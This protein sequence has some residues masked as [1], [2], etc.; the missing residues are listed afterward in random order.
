VCG[1][2]VVG[3]AEGDGPDAGG[4]TDA[5]LDAAVDV[6]TADADALAP[7]LGT[8]TAEL[9]ASAEDAG[10][11]A[12]PF[13][14]D[15][16]DTGDED[17][18]AAPAG[19]LCPAD[20]DDGDGCTID[21][22]DPESGCVHLP[23]D[24]S[25]GDACTAD[26]CTADDG[27]THAPYTCD[28]GDPCT[29]DECIGGQACTNKPVPC[30]DGDA[31]TDDTCLEGECVFSEVVCDDGDPCTLDQC[32]TVLGCMIDFYTN[33]CCATD[34][35]CDDDN[36]C[37]VDSCQ[38]GACVNAVTED[39]SCCQDDSECPGYGECLAGVC[40]AG[41]CKTA[42]VEAPG[43]CA[44]VADC[45]DGDPCTE[46]AC[47]QAECISK[48][49]CCLADADCDD[50]DD[51]CTTDVCVD[52]TCYHPGT[53]A[54]LCCTP[55]LWTADFE[56]GAAGGVTFDNA[57]PGVG[58]QVALS[59]EEGWALY[60]G[61]PEAKSYSTG[62]T[63]NKGTAK[64]P[65]FSLP[66]GVQSHLAFELFLGVQLGTYADRLLVRLVRIEGIEVVEKT[67]VWTKKGFWA[68]NQWVDVS[69]ELTAWAGADVYFEFDFDS[70]VPVTGPGEGIYVDALAVTSTCQARTC[71]SAPEC[72]DALFSTRFECLGGLC[73]YSLNPDN[74]ETHPD[75]DD[76]NACTSDVCGDYK[77]YH[78]D[79]GWCCS[80]DEDCADSFVCTT[81]ACIATV[82]QPFCSHIWNS[83][84][85]DVQQDGTVLF[86]DDK[87]PCTADACPEPGKPCVHT[88][89][90]GCCTD[91]AACVDAEPCTADLCVAG[92]C[93][94]F[95]LC[96]SADD[97]CDDGDDICTA[98]ACEAGVCQ[99]LFLDGEGCCLDALVTEGFDGTGAAWLMPPKTTPAGTAGW[100]KS[101]A[102]ALSL[103][104]SLWFG[105]ASTGT[106]A[107]DGAPSLGTAQT[108]APFEIPVQAFTFLDLWVYLDVE[109]ANAAY[110][111]AEFDRLTLRAQ[112]LDPILGTAK[113]Q[114]LVLW[115]SAWGDPVW[116]AVGPGGGPAGPVWTH[117][118]K[119]DL[120]PLA[121]KTVRI[122]AHF[123]TKDD[124]A[125]GFG[126]VYL[127][128][129][130]VLRTCGVLG[131]EG[132]T[133]E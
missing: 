61:D 77:C 13:G 22:C 23:L 88:P 51:A 128:D 44:S 14:D 121:G 31:C 65:V 129:I 132:D 75:C 81:D 80:S 108:Q 35:E 34:V 24:C 92:Q 33:L 91:D 82:A 119:L 40:A 79:Q 71:D 60:Y 8:D 59:G 20:C 117:L 4:A 74:C 76:A 15:A 102:Q 86:C 93:Q 111:N 46:D 28:D 95:D 56:G 122:E 54:P 50:S 57:Q 36:L 101:S 16:L 62:L 123:D 127:D 114:P 19:P 21:A 90:E 1:V 113:G 99:Y 78:Q 104:S 9:D 37:T 30:W 96:C 70:F 125:N 45:D 12:P 126:G 58:W 94:H 97:D 11:T 32:H 10:D 85:C 17:P 41:V 26:T 5:V 72:D 25:D 63:N 118:E 84:C 131:P 47:V 98:E 120:S 66:K 112:P 39:E 2:A 106:Y 89:I 107:T 27:C 103:P 68:S 53:G 87:D 124:S 105:N 52:G 130:T 42:P 73:V 64:T 110:P 48:L 38:G 109:Y 133:G 29:V 6:E 69:I 115:D 3:C 116:W 18:D 43:C 100:Q 67:L 49:T 83:N 7:E 55:T